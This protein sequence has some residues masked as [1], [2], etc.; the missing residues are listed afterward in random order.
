[1]KTTNHQNGFDIFRRRRIDFVGRWIDKVR[2]VLDAWY[3]GQEGG[4]A[5]TQILF[6]DYSP[7]WQASGIV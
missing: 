4:T 5:L 3:P 1:M 6:G 7:F 2:A